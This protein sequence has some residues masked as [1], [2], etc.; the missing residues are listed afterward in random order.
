M[1]LLLPLVLSA[2]LLPPSNCRAGGWD[3]VV[4]RTETIVSR[5]AEFRVPYGPVGPY[6]GPSCVRISFTIAD[7]G[8]PSDLTI[9]E[10]SRN[11]A[12]DRSALDTLTRYRF[13]PPCLKSKAQVFALVFEYV[14]PASD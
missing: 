11:R 1:S 5:R 8:S 3:R 12:V 7:D 2:A 6:P 14:P 9:D 4:E 13:E 10:S